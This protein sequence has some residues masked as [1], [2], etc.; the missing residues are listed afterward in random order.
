MHQLFPSPSWD[1]I[2]FQSSWQLKEVPLVQPEGLVPFSKVIANTA[3]KKR[4]R[5]DTRLIFNVCEF[6]KT[7]L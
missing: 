6:H 2:P 5:V 1:V 7:S 4:E 3:I